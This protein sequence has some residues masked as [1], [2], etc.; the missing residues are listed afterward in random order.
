MQ[1]GVEAERVD[2]R[3]VPA[4]RLQD[5]A[6]RGV[7]ERQQGQV[8]DQQRGEAE[9]I[10]RDAVFEVE[11]REAAERDLRLD[12]DIGAVGAAGPARVVKQ[13][14]HHLAEGERH[15]D[16]IKPAGE[17]REGADRERRERGDRHGGRQG[18]QR[19]HRRGRR[20][21]EIER[22]GAEP[23]K[24]GVPEAHEPGDADEKVEADHEDREHQHAG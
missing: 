6:E 15:H 8:D 11:Q 5:A 12:I 19:I 16:E 21:E 24:H 18:N 17:H 4:D 14:E 13:R 9:I 20:G 7:R 10:E 3:L 23:E 2:A 22:I 1:V